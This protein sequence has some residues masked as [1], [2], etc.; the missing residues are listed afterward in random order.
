VTRCVAALFGAALVGAASAIA[1]T[2]ATTFETAVASDRDLFAACTPALVAA[3]CDKDGDDAAQS[4]CLASKNVAF[5][6]LRSPKMRRSWLI[7]Y[8]CSES[9]VD[10]PPKPVIAVALAAAP[11]PSPTAA[12]S[13]PAPP[14]PVPAPLAPSSPAP[15]EE[16]PTPVI[17]VTAVPESSTSAKV[18]RQPAAPVRSVADNHGAREQRLRDIIVAHGTEM[19]GCVERQLKLLPTLRAEGTLIIEV[20][21]SGAVPRAEL[22]GADL[23]GTPLESCLQTVASRWRF[24]SNGRAY[25]IDAPVRVWGSALAR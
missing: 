18:A 16:P 25:R 11:P 3:A 24:P 19:K 21:A 8:G 15:P 12:P 6:R 10:A 4:A 23:A 22:L 20:N 2:P 9:I 17:T 1:C 14:P 5:G 13:P 7:S